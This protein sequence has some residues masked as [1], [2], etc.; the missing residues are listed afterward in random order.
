MAPAQGRRYPTGVPGGVRDCLRGQEPVGIPARFIRGCDPEGEERIGQEIEEPNPTQSLPLEKARAPLGLFFWR[1]LLRFGGARRVYHRFV[2][3]NRPGWPVTTKG[4]RGLRALFERHAR[5]YHGV[6]GWFY[7]FSRA[8]VVICRPFAPYR[9][10]SPPGLRHPRKEKAPRHQR[11]IDPTAARPR[12]SP[13]MTEPHIAVRDR[14]VAFR[15]SEP[16]GESRAPPVATGCVLRR[17][18]EPGVT[19]ADT[20]CEPLPTVCPTRGATSPPPPPLWRTA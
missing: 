7:D 13:R 16:E 8:P 11:L 4:P 14:A 10:S 18:T 17:P 12:R 5:G 15:A 20:T 19:A 1:G 2:T 6:R 9:V 3:Q